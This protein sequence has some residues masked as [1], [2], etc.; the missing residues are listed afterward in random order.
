M[1]VL[2]VWAHPLEDSFS[3]VLCRTAVTALARAGHSVDVLDLYRADF[4][5]CLSMDERR[6]YHQRAPAT[7]D[8]T[9]LVDRLRAAEGLLLVYPTWNFGPPAILKGWFD[10]VLLPGVAFTLEGGRTRPALDAIR[11]LGV[12]T[13]YGG[14]RWMVRL[15][16][17][18]PGA[19]LVR[20][21]LARLCP[22]LRGC[23]W[24]A[25]HDMNSPDAGRREAFM[26][27]VDRRLSRW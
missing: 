17:G 14:K 23:D 13:T 7:G 25:L 22:R 2:V 26:A 21:G 1:R 10:R 19:R 15:L 8:V 16:V 4:Q 9:D 11:R 18:D 3:A 24:L 12:V 6:V 20:R 27:E 5:P